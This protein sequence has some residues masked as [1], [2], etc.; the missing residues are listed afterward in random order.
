ML[1]DAPFSITGTTGAPGQN[2][3]EICSNGLKTSGIGGGGTIGLR[4]GAVSATSPASLIYFTVISGSAN[5]L[6]SCC[7]ISSGE[8]P[9][10]I[11]QFTFAWAACGSALGACPPESSVGTHVVRREEL[12][13]GVF[14]NR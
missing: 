12:N 2:F 3:A 9:G 13:I 11:R 14:D 8:C 4:S 7:R 10:K 1:S 5:I 6:I